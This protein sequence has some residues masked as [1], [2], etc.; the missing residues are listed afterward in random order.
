MSA[1]PKREIIARR[2]ARELKDGFVVNL[3][4]GMPTLCANYIPKGID[5]LLHSEN[6][7]LGI[8]PYPF[9]GEE[10]PDLIN[11]GK[12]TVT[13]IRGA[14]YFSSADSFAMIRGGHIDLSVL[15]AM[16]VDER[17]NLANWMVPGKMM[18]GMGGAMDLVASAR[19]VIVAME[20]ATKE[21]QPK[22]LK[23]CKLPL[24]GTEVVDT[25]VTELCFIDVTDRG[26]LLKEIR[27][28]VSIDD[29]QR[30]TGPKL[31]VDGN[32]KPME[33]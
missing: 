30:L 24:T 8:G 28:G 13:E 23:K 9:E 16:E 2:I 29:V 21:G 32:V 15:G 1:L 17:G 19:R 12:E 33:V 25:I 11:A 31:I 5:V 7:L 10:D 3:G 20:H 18:K 14:S 27:P 6:G 26:L 4:I 22:I